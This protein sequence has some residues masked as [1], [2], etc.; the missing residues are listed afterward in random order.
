M[1][2]YVDVY[3]KNIYKKEGRKITKIAIDFLVFFL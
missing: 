1:S 2:N 3:K